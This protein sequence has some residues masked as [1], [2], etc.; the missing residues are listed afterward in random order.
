MLQKRP[1][2]QTAAETFAEIRT[3]TPPTDTETWFVQFP[4]QEDED[5]TQHSGVRQNKHL[6]RRLH[7]LTELAGPLNKWHSIRGP[8]KVQR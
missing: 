7:P 5:R 4:S 6:S 2:S 8:E 3:T 1:P